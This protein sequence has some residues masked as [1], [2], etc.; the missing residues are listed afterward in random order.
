MA[1]D[2][3]GKVFP[4][5][6][7]AIEKEDLHTAEPTE[8]RQV[9]VVS[10]IHGTDKYSLKSHHNKY[11]S[12]DKIGVLSATREAIAHEEGFIP[13]K[14]D[15]GWALQ[16]AR[17]KYVG[18]DDPKSGGSIEIRGDAED[19]GFCQTWIVRGQAKNRKKG[20][21]E[22]DK[23]KDKITRKELEEQAGIKLDDEQVKKLK[24]ARREGRFNEALLD[25]RVKHGKH[26]KFAY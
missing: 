7:E 3:T 12:C 13:V 25:I 16:T 18:V 22:G 17:E 24:R 15:A 19:I 10:K 26:D 23:V 9:W 4:S 21:R 2:A 6:I 11:L 20:K 8:V 1:C 14:T 5:I